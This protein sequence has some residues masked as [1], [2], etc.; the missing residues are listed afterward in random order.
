V[1]Y[2]LD[3]EFNGF[4]GELLSMGLIRED[5]RCFYAYQ[6]L[7]NASK[8]DPFVKR[9]VYPYIHH[10]PL[11]GYTQTVTNHK[12]TKFI[13]TVL[14]N[15]ATPDNVTIVADWPDDIRYFT[16]Q[17][18][19]AP[20]MMI[21]IS[22]IDFQLRRV[23]AYPNALKNCVQHNAMWDAIALRYVLSGQTNYN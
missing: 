13:Q 14:Q 23:D 2:Y 4:G 9:H 5:G 1:K 7:I 12:F 18:I 15:D 20:G 10:T 19:T 8:L 16:E 21:N 11:I 3:T 17:L 6:G 22:S